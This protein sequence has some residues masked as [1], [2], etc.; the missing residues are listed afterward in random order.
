[1]HRKALVLNDTPRMATATLSKKCTLFHD[2]VHKY[3]HTHS[4]TYMLKQYLLLLGGIHCEVFCSMFLYLK[5]ISELQLCN[6]LYKAQ[7]LQHRTA[8]EH[9]QC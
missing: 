2:H 4:H 5:K 1:M 9:N 8:L 3:K 6:K 7:M